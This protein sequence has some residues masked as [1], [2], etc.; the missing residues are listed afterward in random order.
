MW[1]RAGGWCHPVCTAGPWLAG[2]EADLVQETCGEATG[3]DTAA[4]TSSGP[5]RP[6]I[7]RGVVC[8]TFRLSLRLPFHLRS[9]ITASG[10]F[11]FN[12]TV[13]V[14]GQPLI[15]GTRSVRGSPLADGAP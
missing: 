4:S 13:S 14:T 8:A 1:G 3:A 2:K 12:G 5:A 15:N 9:L 11:W 6:R 10:L 7:L